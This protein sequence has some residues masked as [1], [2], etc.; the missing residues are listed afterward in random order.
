MT[1]PIDAFFGTRILL[2][3]TLTLFAAISDVRSRRIPNVLLGTF[4]A[5]GLLAWFLG[6]G[7]MGL[8]FSLG[9]ALL[10]LIALLPLFVL[11]ALA[12]GD[13][14]L[15]AVIAGLTGIETFIPIFV[16]S[17]VAGGIVGSLIWIRSRSPLQWRKSHWFGHGGFQHESGF[18]EIEDQDARFPFAFPILMGTLL[19]ILGAGHIPDALARI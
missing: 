19:G 12:G 7:A 9:P 4:M 3:A 17:L 15:F 6:R 11:R 8:W 10:V 1:D 18:A 16:M 13:V 5:L 2:V 14:K